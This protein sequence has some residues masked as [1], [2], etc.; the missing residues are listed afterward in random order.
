MADFKKTIATAKAKI[1]AAETKAFTA[2]LDAIDAILRGASPYDVM[3]LCA[4]ALA[5]VAPLCCEEHEAAFREDFLQMLAEA[6]EI[7][8]QEQDAAEA[9]DDD[10]AHT[11][12]H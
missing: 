12:V 11:S 2:R 7:Q 8:Q 9:D 3:M 6:V 1:D 4:H 5:P 10:D